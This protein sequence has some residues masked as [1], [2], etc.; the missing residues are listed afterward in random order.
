[1]SETKKLFLNGF[2]MYL[3]K[4][5]YY[6]IQNPKGDELQVHATEKYTLIKCTKKDFL[7]EVK[8]IVEFEPNYFKVMATANVLFAI[9]EKTFDALPTKKDIEKYINE[10]IKSIINK[11]PVGNGLALLIGQITSSFGNVP[12]IT[13][14]NME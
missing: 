3:D 14:G 11:T 1:M 5:E 6:F 10:N 9:D 4:I 7:I 2:S 8:R 13:P 12:V